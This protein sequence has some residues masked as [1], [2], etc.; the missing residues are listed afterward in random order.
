MTEVRPK[1]TRDRASARASCTGLTTPSASWS[2]VAL[3]LAL[4]IALALVWF[5]VPRRA[6]ATPTAI[7]KATAQTLFDDAMKLM[8]SKNYVEACPKLE[9][10]QRLDVAMGT[11]FRLAECYEGMGR[12]ASAWANYVDVA[13]AAKLA[14]Q[15]DRERVARER[16]TALQPR[17]SRLAIAVTTPDLGGLEV[18]R[19]DVV[20]GRAQWGSAIPVDPGTYAVRAS[21]PGKMSWSASIVV[22]GDGASHVVTVPALEDGAALS[23][24]TQ[25]TSTDSTKR[26]S[27]QRT[28]GLLVAGGGVVAM[29]AS[30]VLG[31]VAK[32]NY[33]E[34]DP[35]CRGAI[36]DAQG[37]QKTDDARTL[38]GVATIV[39]G[40]GAAATVGGIVLFATAPR[41]RGTSV[42][43][44][45]RGLLVQGSF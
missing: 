21:A 28:I 23:G 30:G 45:P 16:A 33:G 43:L 26:G 44:G 11:Q 5:A 36:C 1:R 3:R 19:G 17:L 42:G 13:D 22:N 2:R 24:R 20:L 31:L 40:V 34:A 15:I 4:A 18:R 41:R 35:H 25:P 14:G 27:S 29:G 7:D 9:E 39:F 38:A 8:L 37:K 10:S 32:S 6:C 12:T